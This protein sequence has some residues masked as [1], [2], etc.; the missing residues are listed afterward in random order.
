MTEDTFRIFEM[1]RQ[2]IAVAFVDMN[3]ENS[4]ISKAS[5]KLVDV[6]L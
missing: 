3:N 2:P 4:K 6:T 1:I 5:I